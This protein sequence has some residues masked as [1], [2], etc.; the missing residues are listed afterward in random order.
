MSGILNILAAIKGAAAVVTDTYFNLVTLLLNTSSTNGAQNNTFLDSSSNNF[1]ITRNGNTTQ[2][3][4]TPFSQTGWSNYFNGDGGTTSNSNQFYFADN[5]ALELGSSDFCIEAW[6]YLTATPTTN[7]RICDKDAASNTSYLLYI[8]SSSNPVF[9]FSTNGS[10]VTTLTSTGTVSKN[11][12]THI[13]LTRSGST[14]TFW[15]NGV[16]SGTSTN[17]VTI[18]NGNAVLRIGN[19][20][21]N[22][23]C[24]PG[25]ISNFR[26]VTGVPVYTTGFTPSTTPLTAISGTQ[27]LTC[28]SNRF[29]D[30]SS[31][32]F[33]ITVNGTPSVQAFSPFAPTAAYSTSVVGG[34][35]YFDG[36]GDYLSVSS[37]VA[38]QLSTGDFTVETWFY[39]TNATNVTQ[40]LITTTIGAYGSTDFG[41]RLESGSSQHIRVL[42]GGTSIEPTS[43][44]IVGNQWYH[45]AIVRNGSGTNN[46]TIYLNGVNIAQGTSTA[47]IS[48]A[49]QYIGGYFSTGPT[50]YFSGYLSNVR[51]VKGTAVYTAN[52]TP[53]TAL[54]TAITNT[55]LLLN[56][57]NAGIYDAAA[58]NVSETVGNAQV[59]TTQAKFGTTSM[60]FDGTGDYLILPYNKR[61]DLTQ[62]DFTIEGWFYRAATGVEHNILNNRGANIGILWRINAANTVTFSIQGSTITTITSTG[63]IAANTWT[64][65]A[66]TRSGA[67]LRIFINGTIDGSSASAVNGTSSTV[68]LKV[69]CD[70]NLINAFNGY[71]DELRVTNGYAR[72]TANFSVPTAAF[73]VQ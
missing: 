33:A 59:S 40:R 10:A 55:S 21:T 27:L 15:I 43:P 66:V 69:G 18:F 41:L 53:P 16:S 57:T 30:N 58:K 26:L 23:R 70:D 13:A 72:Y 14:F 68:T 54:L 47:N 37:N 71:M 35:G 22:D 1:T 11:A 48:T 4:F 3:T 67:N 51:I 31:N 17:S 62:G 36:S 29:V 42:I 20:S 5:A 7:V 63:T 6:I 44:T 50:E 19:T 56:Y 52:F 61:Q 38:L 34:S 73:P 46:C 12:W 9:N 8:N 39:A 60:Y 65:I 25:Y 64:Y 2:G 32:A 45:I 49:I 24:F 28:Q